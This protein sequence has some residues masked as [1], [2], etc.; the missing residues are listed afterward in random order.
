[1]HA[2]V[3]MPTCA[4]VEQLGFCT[5][6][7]AGAAG[8]RFVAVNAAAA[9]CLANSD[10]SSVQG[11]TYGA[12]PPLPANRGSLRLSEAPSLADLTDIRRLVVAPRPPQAQLFVH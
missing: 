11:C 3:N 6:T 7:I 10:D 4:W 1:M 8:K 12:L 2:A 5:A 9:A